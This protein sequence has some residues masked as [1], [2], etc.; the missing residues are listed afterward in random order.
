MNKLLIVEDNHALLQSLCQLLEANNYECVTAS[1]VAEA[2]TLLH[3]CND[4]D[5]YLLDLNLPDGNGLDVC[6]IIRRSNHTPI[7]FLT[8]TNSEDMI[9]TALQSGADD[10]ITKPFRMGELTARIQALLRRSQLYQTSQLIHTADLVLDLEAK[11]VLR[12][13]TPINLRPT[14]FEI[15]SQLVQADTRIVHRNI[16]LENIWDANNNFV[17]ENTLSVH[18]S[19]LRNNLGTYNNAR[20]FETIWGIGYRWIHKIIY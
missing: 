7:I 4:F 18:V 2:T 10:Y 11:T 6:K 5:L 13:N 17:D 3:R 14:E 12:N 16:L 1:S 20:Y 8:A 19:R 15:L 9:I